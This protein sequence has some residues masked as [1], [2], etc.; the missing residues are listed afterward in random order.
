MV[1]GV[2]QLLEDHALLPSVPRVAV[3]V[4]VAEVEVGDGL[5]ISFLIVRRGTRQRCLP[6][7]REF[8]RMILLSL[9][10]QVCPHNLLLMVSA[11]FAES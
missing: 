1:T 6:A 11:C 10:P 2:F 5:W 4:K 8:C 9:V 3:L 7:C